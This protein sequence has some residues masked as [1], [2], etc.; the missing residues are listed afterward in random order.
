M[1]IMLLLL[2]LAAQEAVIIKVM[3]QLEMA[4]QPSLLLIRQLEE[5]VA[6]ALLME[7]LK[8]GIA[9]QKILVAALLDVLEVGRVAQR[10]T[11]HLVN[12]LVAMAQLLYFCLLR[13]QQLYL[14]AAEVAVVMS[15]VM[16]SLAV[17]AE[18]EKVVW[19]TAQVV[20]VIKI[21]MMFKTENP[22]LAVV[23][24]ELVRYMDS[25]L[26]MCVGNLRRQINGVLE[27]VAMA[28]VVL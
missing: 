7:D 26:E 3:K 14:A 28:E 17:P 11:L 6:E 18:A 20:I 25:A 4:E 23:A 5:K 13:L 9:L 22:T 15:L 16:V 8:D 1:K 2:E 27:K 19:V 10:A 21:R 24:A 12:K